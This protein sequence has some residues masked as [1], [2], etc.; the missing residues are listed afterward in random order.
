MKGKIRFY[1][2]LMKTFRNFV[3]Q[4]IKKTMFSR[5]LLLLILFTLISPG[6]LDAQG[7]KD[8]VV[9]ISTQFG[10]MKVILFDKTPQHKANFLKLAT[11][12][13]YDSTFF[14][15]VINNFM[16]QGGDPNTKPGGKP[17][18]AGQGGPGYT[19]PAEFVAEY[20]HI[21]GAL[22]AARQGDQINPTKAS[23]G[24]QFY[25]VHNDEGCRHLNGQYT[26]FGQVIK[27]FEVID[28]VATQPVNRGRGDRPLKD[29]VITM[30]VEKM[31]RKKIA[32]LYGYEYP[33]AESEKEKAKKK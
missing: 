10:E 14:H 7:K 24:S 8:Q 27:G 3:S 9:T 5:F 2:V 19:I 11:E 30:T 32:K 17:E 20:S 12:G 25:I 18:L 31:S 13:F 28:A 26:V 4:N 16:I 29:I 33:V 22:A 15:R 6:V 23:S 21:K 1:L